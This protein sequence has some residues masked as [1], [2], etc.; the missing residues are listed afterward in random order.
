[1]GDP[2]PPSVI[3]N[4]WYRWANSN[5]STVTVETVT[6]RGHGRRMGG[7]GSVRPKKKSLHI[8]KMSAPVSEGGQDDDEIL[9]FPGDGVVDKTD[10]NPGVLGEHHEGDDSR[11]DEAGGASSQGSANKRKKSAV[12]STDDHVTARIKELKKKIRGSKR[13]DNEWT[14]MLHLQVLQTEQGGTQ[15]VRTRPVPVVEC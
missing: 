13:E 3:L 1:M 5:P 6:V 15:T 8:I 10:S 11:I 9:G 12:V 4:G 2:N 7:R 14:K